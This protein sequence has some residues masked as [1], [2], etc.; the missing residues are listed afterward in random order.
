MKARLRPILF[1]SCLSEVKDI[2]E[3]GMVTFYASIFGNVDRAME[4]VD[5]GAYSKT[6][7]ESYSEIQHYKNH[8]SKLMPGVIQELLEDNTG[9]L[10]KSKLILSTELGRDT[11]EQ[12]K[13][14]AE[15]GKSMGHS[16]GYSVT[17]DSEDS[18]QGIRH[19]KELVL[20]EVSSLTMRAANS[21][22][23][24]VGIKSIDELD[25]SELIKEE[26]FYTALLNCKF[27]YAKLENLEQIKNH[28]SALIQSHAD[29]VHLEANA[30]LKKS[31]VINLLF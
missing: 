31:E 10:V 14:M 6:I 22:A 19:L 2:D 11:Y 27:E 9:L 8:D 23:L 3:K 4:V 30:P 7:S 18:M 21:E 20:Y 12:Y 24:T 15:V 26:K 29:F 16:I 13:A 17:R 25:F 5:K 1:K 28:I